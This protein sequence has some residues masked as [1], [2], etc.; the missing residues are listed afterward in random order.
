[1]D[2]RQYADGS[3]DSNAKVGHLC[4]EINNILWESIWYDTFKIQ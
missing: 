3:I 4:K 2:F 1:M